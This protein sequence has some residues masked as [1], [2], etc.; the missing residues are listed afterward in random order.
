MPRQMRGSG[1]LLTEPLQ[2]KWC[3]DVDDDDDGPVD[4]NDAIDIT[5]RI[6]IL[7]MIM[8]ILQ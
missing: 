3:D 7:T 2:N 6:F 1:P 5:I 8:L 4:D